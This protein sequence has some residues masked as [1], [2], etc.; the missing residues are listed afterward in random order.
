[1]AGDHLI[2]DYLATV[3]SRLRWRHDLDDIEAELRDHLCSATERLIDAGIDDEEA[4][5][6]VLDRFGD[7]GDVAVAFASAG[8]RGVALPTKFSRAG[9]AAALFAAA[10]WLVAA[11]AFGLAWI[12]EHRTGDW[13]GRSQVAWGLGS[14]SL[15]ASMVATAFLVRALDRRHG[16]LGV[17]GRLGI[18]LA[19]LA[20][21][22]SIISWFFVLW[23]LLLGTGAVL[24]TL[25]ILGRDLAPLV[26]TVTFGATAVVSA[27]TFA[28]LRGLEVGT[29]DEW[30]DYPIANRTTIAVACVGFAAACFGLGRWLRS[31]TPVDPADL[32]AVAA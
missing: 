13:G 20:S 2:D 23:G 17:L 22:A 29:A 16:G 11:S 32:P 18:A 8:S 15:L 25:A 19:A 30:G 14:I 28:V 1:M 10:G 26:P 9:G 12:F 4:H 5:H 31:E 27:L 21:V 24:I 6:R 3:R 7:S